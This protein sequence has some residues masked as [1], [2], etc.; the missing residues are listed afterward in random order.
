MILPAIRTLIL[1]DSVISGMV[2]TRVMPYT[3]DYDVTKPAIAIRVLPA[4]IH[5]Q[6]LTGGRNVRQNVITVDCFS[7]DDWAQC[8]TLAMRIQ[9]PPIVGFR[10]EIGNV[11]IQGIATDGSFQHDVDGIEPASKRRICV[12]TVDFDVVWSLSE[13]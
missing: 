8:D 5:S 11:F 10:G 7:L 1:Q 2:G 13:I 4:N 9:A 3:I 6:V 12:S